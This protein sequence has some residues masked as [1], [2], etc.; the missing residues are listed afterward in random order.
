[1][2]MLMLRDEILAN[3]LSLAPY[4]HHLSFCKELQTPDISYIS[5]RASPVRGINLPLRC[6]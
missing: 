1:L 5:T 3:M 6:L 4:R 2:S